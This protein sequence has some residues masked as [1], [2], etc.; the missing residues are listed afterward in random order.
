MLPDI[1]GLEVLRRVR[2]QA[3]E[4]PVLFLTA[5]DAVEDRVAGLTA[6]CDDYITKPFSTKPFSIEERAGPRSPSGCRRGPRSAGERG[7]AAGAVAG[8]QQ[9][10]VQRALLPAAAGGGDRPTSRERQGGTP[11][12]VRQ[13]DG[14]ST[15]ARRGGDGVEVH[16]VPRADLVGRAGGPASYISLL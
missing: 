7:G 4:V 8:R 16:R 15:G 2:A 12:A 9:V 5:R 6:G 1:D 3:P 13:R 10:L 11:G 14:R